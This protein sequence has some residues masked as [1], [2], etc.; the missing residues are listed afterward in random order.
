MIIEII[1]III[2]NIKLTLCI[3]NRLKYFLM[4]ITDDKIKIS[5]IKSY[6]K[7]ASRLNSMLKKADKNKKLKN[8]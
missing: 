3:Y 6:H 2:I 1:I 5:R 4:R 7:N 8:K